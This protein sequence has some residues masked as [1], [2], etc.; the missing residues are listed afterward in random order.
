MRGRD[1]RASG[2]C[3][4]AGGEVS[5]VLIVIIASGPDKGQ[6]HEFSDN[7]TVVLGRTTGPIQFTDSK[8]SRQ[9]VRLWCEGGQWFCCDLDSRHGSYR[10]NKPVSQ[11]RTQIKDG[12]RLQIGRTVLVMSRV[13]VEQA[14]KMELLDDPANVPMELPEEQAAKQSTATAKPRRPMREFAVG[15]A[16]A[17]AIGLVAMNIFMLIDARRHNAAL[18]Q[19]LATQ[20]IASSANP[21]AAGASDQQDE[22]RRMLQD[23]LAAVRAAPTR[24][25]LDAV[26]QQFAD[27]RH[28]D[29]GRRDLLES[30][31]AEVKLRQADDP[32]V[33]S[34]LDE[35]L[36][37]VREQPGAT[38]A[39]VRE[40]LAQFS[41][42]RQEQEKMLRELFAAV[43]DQ[44]AKLDEART[45][46]LAAIQAQP[47]PEQAPDHEPLLRQ[48]LAKLDERGQ[49]D[50]QATAR[51]IEA[52]EAQP[53]QTRELLEQVLAKLDARP[54]VEPDP[55]LDEVL[56]ALQREPKDIEPLLLQLTA[57]LDA[58]SAAMAALQ[59]KPTREQMVSAIEAAVADLPAKQAN[60]MRQV[61]AEV[62]VK[63]DPADDAVLREILDSVKQQPTREQLSAAID[64]AMKK[65]LEGGRDG[66][67][68]LR[69][70]L[71]AVQA[72]PTKEQLAE[73]IEE[74]I[75]AQQEA[76]DSLLQMLYDDLKNRPTQEQI[77]KSLD[78]ALASKLGPRDQVLAEILAQVS[79]KPDPAQQQILA[80]ILAAVKAQPEQSQAMLQQVLT[81][82][83][84]PLK[85]QRDP[86]LDEVLAAVQREPKDSEPLLREIA[87]KLAEA[88]ASGRDAEARQAELLQ[89]IA[90]GIESQ[91]AQTRELVG[92]VLAKLD[93]P[94]DTGHETMLREI[95]A[96]MKER[97][98]IDGGDTAVAG[99]TGDRHEQLLRQVLA[100]L[101]SR[102]EPIAQTVLDGLRGELREQVQLAMSQAATAT[103]PAAPSARGATRPA[104]PPPADHAVAR[105][106][107]PAANVSIYPTG[108]PLAAF[109]VH[110]VTGVPRA[111]TGEL[112]TDTQLAYKRAW[113]TGLPQMVGGRVEP[114][115]GQRVDGRTLDPTR[116]RSMGIT[117]WQ[118]WYMIDDLAEQERLRQAATQFA[119]ARPSPLT[120]P[121]YQVA[122]GQA[123]QQST[124]TSPTVAT[125]RRVAFV[126]DA[127]EALGDDMPLATGKLREMIEGLASEDTFT[128]L[129][130]QDRTV[131]EVPPRGLKPA[132]PRAAEQ[133]AQWLASDGGNI[134]PRGSANPV[135]ALQQAMAIKPD[136]VYLISARITGNRGN[137][138][139]SPALI[140]AVAK[141]PH[142]E[143]TRLHGV[144][145]RQT[146]GHDTLRRLSETYGGT[147]RLVGAPAASPSGE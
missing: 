9:H 63:A 118:D 71:A 142:D 115:T 146:D 81:K 37:A 34:K 126:L 22:T 89:Q 143:R 87:T 23:V 68:M 73:A 53:R 46:I 141:L 54:G 80:D 43:Q 75:K 61:L 129:V 107:V 79:A 127:S 59:D 99:M 90:A 78:E 85:T 19:Q 130:Y 36:A 138:L 124:A 95:L 15:L 112:L 66:E 30:I 3:G 111:Q 62:Q 60:T 121:L 136:D 55:R 69:D 47:T 119:A 49:A 39:A 72:Q 45:Q 4:V 14:R 18:R 7:E 84:E 103:T 137:A 44:P 17:A 5:P 27:V 41:E 29:T 100:E 113:E 123:A 108:D 56:A 98:A 20:P 10:N 50:E 92:Q 147:Y 134:R 94:A 32:Q 58:Q 67:A 76:S 144:E 128:V 133:V 145:L 131:T 64:A 12:D 33:G 102:S 82:L 117:R 13:P 109:D 21:G 125:P 140:A 132:T 104:A 114:V 57:K 96:A 116:A 38:Q 8:I 2:A 40:Q 86:V 105:R 31:L 122:S 110:R 28:A 11:A 106:D 88:T 77:E 93:A 26:V 83:D 35:V 135:A 48:V 101:R 97:E 139:S 52:V 65:Q 70:V 25:Q 6:V 120:T 42:S 51:V 16:A 74:K 91:P 24:E 1:R